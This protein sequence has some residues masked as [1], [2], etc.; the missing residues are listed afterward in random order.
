[1][2]Y[3]KYITFG[4]QI[5]FEFKI[6]EIIQISFIHLVHKPIQREGC[7]PASWPESPEG[8]L[9]PVPDPAAGQAHLEGKEGSSGAI[10][11]QGEMGNLCFSS[12]QSRLW[13][14]VV[15]VAVGQIATKSIYFGNEVLINISP[16]KINKKIL[17]SPS[18]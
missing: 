9:Q 3:K 18:R 11:Q 10:K 12:S 13:G 1:M 5:R 4:D 16:D 14:V 8:M 15:A 6:L 17:N 7:F 2:A